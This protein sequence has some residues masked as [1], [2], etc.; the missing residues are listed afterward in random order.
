VPPT[1][2]RNRR[3]TID[4]RKCRV[5]DLAAEG[6]IV[7]AVGGRPTLVVAQVDSPGRYFDHVLLLRVG[8]EPEFLLRGASTS[9][10]FFDHFTRRSRTLF[11][12]IW[13]CSYNVVYRN[14]FPFRKAINDAGRRL[15]QLERDILDRATVTANRHGPASA[16]RQNEAAG[17]TSTTLRPHRS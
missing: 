5:H 10:G 6:P 14:R 11:H 12:T 1:N 8:L 15:L 9:W 7:V 16:R 17:S 13:C 3:I 2:E 4:G